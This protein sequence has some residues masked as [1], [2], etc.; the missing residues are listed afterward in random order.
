MP[1]GSETFEPT[2]D[3]VSYNSQ[4]LRAIVS[5]D[6]LSSPA[7][8]ALRLYLES[9]A[10]LL[11]YFDDQLRSTTS[12]LAFHPASQ[13]RPKHDPRNY[14][15]N[16]VSQLWELEDYFTQIPEHAK[17]LIDSGKYAAIRLHDHFTLAEKGEVG[18]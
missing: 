17:V 14:L 1:W 2:R 9:I 7:R 13:I 6:E 8:D 10:A 18:P 12:P 11:K 16:V 5:F 4:L 15:A 3:S